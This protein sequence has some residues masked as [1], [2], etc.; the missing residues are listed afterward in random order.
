MLYLEFQCGGK[1]TNKNA[2]F[3]SVGEEIES[4]ATHHVNMMTGIQ[5]SAHSTPPLLQSI[6]L[7]QGFVGGFCSDISDV[8]R[9]SGDQGIQSLRSPFV[10]WVRIRN[11]I[12]ST[13]PIRTRLDRFRFHSSP[14]DWAHS[15]SN[16]NKS[17]H[18]TLDSP[19]ERNRLTCLNLGSD[20][21]SLDRQSDRQSRSSVW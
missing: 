5:E 13:S 14:S 7:L 15:K 4:A 3:E 17:R 12:A 18:P 20:D 9:L 6:V 16:E 21:E 8:P 1:R 2:G 11:I 10:L 19:I